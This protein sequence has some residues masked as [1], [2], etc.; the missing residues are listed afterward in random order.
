VSH[1]DAR[2]FPDPDAFVPERFAPPSAIPRYAYLPFGAGPHVCIGA[3]L[4]MLEAVLVVAT[5]ARRWQFTAQRGASVVPE[6]LVSVRPSP[7]VRVVAH[8]RDRAAIS[9]TRPVLVALPA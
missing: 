7:G 9:G 5:V 4:A 1:H 2:Y 3:Q 6:A 8:A